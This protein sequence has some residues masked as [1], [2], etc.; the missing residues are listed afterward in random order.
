MI[1]NVNINRSPNVVHGDIND[2]LQELAVYYIGESVWPVI[3]K[4]WDDLG[5]QLKDESGFDYHEGD[6]AQVLQETHSI[7][8]EE[9]DARWAQI[10][11][12]EKENE[13]L[14]KVPAGAK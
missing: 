4:I 3:E 9:L 13:A 10:D 7:Y 1:V 14:R 12:L 6:L 2:K 5:F 8:K 11:K